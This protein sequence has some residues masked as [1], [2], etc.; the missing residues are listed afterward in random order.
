LSAEALLPN[1]AVLILNTM[2]LFRNT[3]TLLVT[4]VALLR[5]TV[6]LLM[7]VVAQFIIQYFAG[8]SLFK[9]FLSH[10]LVDMRFPNSK[11]HWS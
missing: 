5:N 6:A 11:L 2:A 8:N 9:N 10:F 1:T 4:T 3:V 7:T